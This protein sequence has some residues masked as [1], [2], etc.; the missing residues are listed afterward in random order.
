[1]SLISLQI[2]NLI[3]GVSQQP[4]Q[5]R[6]P[7]Q[8][9]EQTNA[10]PSLT[11]GLTKRPPT[12]HVERLSDTQAPDPFIHFINRDSVE[13]Y[14]VR[15]TST[16]LKV[17]TLAGVE[18][19]IYDGL[20]GSTAFTFPPYLNTPAN[21]RA[22]TVADYTF[23]LNTTTT[24]AMAGTTTAAAEQK[25]LVAI[26]Q[27]SYGT[28]YTVTIRFSNVDYAYSHTT[29]STTTVPDTEVIAGALATLI[30]GGTTSTHYV[31]ASFTGSTIVLTQDQTSGAKTF[32]VKTS[33]SAGGTIMS[34]A[35]GKVARISDLPLAA[36]H[37]FKI[38]IGA[39]IEDPSTSDYYGIFIANDGIT[40]SGRWEESVGFGVT[41]TLSDTTLPYVLVRRADGNFGCYKPTW[42][43]RLVGDAVTAAPP[44]FVGRKINDMFLYRNR[45]GFLADN[46]VVMSEAGNYFGFWRTTSTQII[47]SDP[48][49]VSVAHSQVSSLRAAVGWDER[50]IL[51]TDTTQFS[52]GSGADTNLTPETVEIVQT[53]DFENFSSVC[54]PQP[55]GRSLL[56]IQSK[57]QNVGVREYVRISVDEKYDG[58]DIT[59]N[60]PAYIAGVPQQIAV[61]THDSTAFLRTST[62]LYNHK[63]FVNGSEKIQSAWSKWDLGADAVVAGMH[64]YD[65][66]LYMVVT[67]GAETFLEKVEFEGRFTDPGLTWG[68]HLDRRAVAT[69]VAG[70]VYGTTKFLYSPNLNLSAYS[71][72]VVANGIKY[73]PIE[74][75]STEVVVLANLVGTVAWVGVPY[76]MRWTFSKQYARN[77][78]KPIIDGRLQLTYGVLS[79][80]ETGNFKVEVTPK[81]RTPFSYTFDGSILG[82]SLLA[83]TPNLVT[84]SFRFPVHCRAAD[85]KVSVVSTSHLPCRIQSAS[86]EANYST[87]N[88][89]I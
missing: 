28:K 63:W 75:T 18:K 27:G 53:T 56:F 60:I 79:F 54:K 77:Q 74:V 14:V 43:L 52:L 24:V 3:Q 37:G 57:G 69:G 62:G 12:N 46:K 61:S 72:V 23:L 44:S 81:Y 45:L 5:M 35:K 47:D 58:L 36:P 76:E 25:A 84:D 15:G 8:L 26:I 89:T 17:F 40:G 50:L 34:A 29:A 2:P 59:A 65:H 13:R 30:N 33:D 38:A 20:T 85:A 9:E 82:G 51:F 21:L 49:D 86:F 64:W 39:D 6:L 70:T 73:Q 42:D 78:D 71:P 16:T 32:T 31:A 80:E 4:P 66:I 67:R 88:R 7:S 11:E 83:S 19:T 22:L 10:Y 68:V 41:T 48:I 55:T 1:M 87:R